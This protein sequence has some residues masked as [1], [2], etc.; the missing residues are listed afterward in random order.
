MR[1]N[2]PKT[3]RCEY[4]GATDRPT[5]YAS[6][7][8]RYTRNRADWFEFCRRCHNAF[9]GPHSDETKAKISAANKGRVLSI[10]TRRRMSAARK[11]VPFSAEHR[12]KVSASLRARA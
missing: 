11:G 9:D 7:G 5:E 6:V 2:Y 12:A 3:G 4:C 8:H 1:R 10:E